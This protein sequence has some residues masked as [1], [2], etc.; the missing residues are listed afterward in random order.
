MNEIVLQMFKKKTDT[1]SPI[2]VTYTLKDM[3]IIKI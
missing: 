3:I 1:K 2:L